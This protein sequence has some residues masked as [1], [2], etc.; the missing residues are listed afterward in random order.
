MTRFERRHFR[1][2]AAWLLVAGL[3]CGSLGCSRT[4]VVRTRTTFDSSA[5]PSEDALYVRQNAVASEGAGR[6]LIFDFDTNTEI[7]VDDLRKTYWVMTLDELREQ[8][9]TAKARYAAW[10]PEELRNV[11]PP[12]PTVTP[13]G[14]T[15]TI[16]GYSATEYAIA[17]NDVSG[18]VW[19]TGAFAMPPKLRTWERLHRA[20]PRLHGGPDFDA[21]ADTVAGTPLRTVRTITVEARSS[22]STTDVVDAG[23]GWAPLGVFSVPSGYTRVPTPDLSRHLI[24]QDLEEDD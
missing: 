3:V 9:Q 5:A 23:R 10:F 17:G 15:R 11:T 22:T 16:A 21:A 14:R 13:T 12:P 6:R 7:S 24:R 1:T 8:V 4:F 18:A 2:P 19:V 20:I